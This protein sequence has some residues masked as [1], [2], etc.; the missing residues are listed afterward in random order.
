[1][2]H[3]SAAPD[4]SPRPGPHA[5]R[6]RARG[7]SAKGRFPAIV[8][9]TG[10]SV[11]R[12]TN[13]PRMAMRSSGTEAAQVVGSAFDRVSAML[14][15]LALPGSSLWEVAVVTKYRSE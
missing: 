2:R 6:C 10:R 11:R 4:P 12:L 3:M 13:L 14:H 15:P 9:V 8:P 5:R 7:L 1:M